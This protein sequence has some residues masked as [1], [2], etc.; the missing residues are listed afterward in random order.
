[1]LLWLWDLVVGIH[2]LTTHKEFGSMAISVLNREIV[3]SRAAVPPVQRRHCLAALRAAAIL[4]SGV[5]LERCPV[6]GLL[7]DVIRIGVQQRQLGVPES[8]GGVLAL[9]QF[10]VERIHQLRRR[11]VAD[12][13]QR[14]DNIVGAGPEESPGEANQSLARI[15]A[16]AGAIACGDG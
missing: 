2:R 7:E 6:K 8:R 14:A 9:A 11:G 5:Q 16:R 3:S 15:G 10:S 1:M 4:R 12:L 13:P